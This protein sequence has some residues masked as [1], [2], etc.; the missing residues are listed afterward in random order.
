MKLW[1]LECDASM[2]FAIVFANSKEEA[3]E[4]LKTYRQIDSKEYELWIV[5]EFTQDKYDGI[6]LFA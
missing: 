1:Y 3:F 4:K 2:E 6:L 5:E